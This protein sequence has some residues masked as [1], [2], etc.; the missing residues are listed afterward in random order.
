MIP[1]H[2]CQAKENLEKTLSDTRDPV[3]GESERD[4]MS[5]QKLEKHFENLSVAYT[6]FIFHQWERK[7]G[8]REE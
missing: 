2:P 6:C 8:K 1:D 7:D 4:T 3:R 5:Q